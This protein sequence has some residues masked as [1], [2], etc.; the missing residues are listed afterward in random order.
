MCIHG[1][2]DNLVPINQSE[3]LN[4]ALRKQNVPTALIKIIRGGHGGFINPDI[5]KVERQFIDA[6]I[7]HSDKLPESMVLPNKPK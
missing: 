5:K 2:S 4:E 6:I 1:D 3:L 7:S